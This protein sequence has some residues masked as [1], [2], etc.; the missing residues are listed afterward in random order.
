MCRQAIRGASYKLFTDRGL[1]ATGCSCSGRRQ[2][3]SVSPLLNRL[4]PLRNGSDDFVGN[5][6]DVDQWLGRGVEIRTLAQ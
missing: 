1:S 3:V 4:K 5:H 2:F 6:T